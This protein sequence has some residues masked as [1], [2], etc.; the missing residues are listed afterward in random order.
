MNHNEL[1]IVN[2]KRGNEKL[3]YQG[4]AYNLY[5]TA[6]SIKQ[7]RCTNRKCTGSIKT[8]HSYKILTI[9][10][11]K[12][13]HRNY[14]KNEADFSR[15]NMY[16]RALKTK[17]NP[18][19]I[20]CY[21]LKVCSHLIANELSGI[22]IL[23]DKITALRGRKNVKILKDDIPES[24]KF[25]YSNEGIL[26]IDTGINNFNRI[27]FFTTK[28]NSM[29]L[30]NSKILYC[31]G[32]FYSCPKEFSQLYVIMPEVKFIKVPLVFVFLKKKSKTS[33]LNVLKII[34]KEI[35]SEALKMITIDFEMA[36]FLEIKQIFT[37]SKIQGC[38]F[39]FLSAFISIC[40]AI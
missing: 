4:Y 26:Q 23:R 39:S 38:F 1:Y 8:D 17:E 9:K 33:Y 35:N 25:T 15:Y 11:H 28:T 18:S 21:E 40:T 30:K 32:T 3:L 6:E 14:D 12:D 19:D 29:H 37:E 10:N 22:H 27:L 5:K 16:L 20:I 13:K 2:T 34:K 7:W 36:A 24:I 31:D